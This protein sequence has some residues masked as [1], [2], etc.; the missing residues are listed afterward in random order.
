[1][2]ILAVNGSLKGS[3]GNTDILLRSFRG[4]AQDAGAE[5]HM[6]L[7]QGQENRPLPRLLNLLE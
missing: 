4:G 1:M 2:K 3:A 7:S 6:I 5:I